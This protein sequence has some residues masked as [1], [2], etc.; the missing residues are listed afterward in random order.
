MEP[1]IR[2]KGF[3]SEWSKQKAQEIFKTY[4]DRNHPELPVLSA[5]QDIRGMAPRSTSGYDIFHD[6]ANEVTY[7]RVLPGQFVIHLRSFQGGFAHSAIEGICSPAYTVFEFKNKDEHD[8]Y[9]WKHVLRSM[10]F[11]ERLPLITYGIRD[12]RSISFKEFSDLAFNFPEKSEQSAIASFFKKMYNQIENTKKKITSFRQMR[13]ASLQAMFPQKGSTKPQIRFKGFNKDWEMNTLDSY[14]IPS[15]AKNTD[16]KYSKEDV[17]SVSGEYGIVNQIAFQG[18]SFAGLS[19]L[20]YGVVETKN[21]VYTKSPLKLNPYGIIK[22]N[23]GVTGIVSTLYAIYKCVESVNPTFVQYY[24]ELDS[25]LNDYLRPL[26]QKGAKNDMKISSEGALIGNVVFPSYDEQTQIADYFKTL[27]KKIQL[28]EQKLE[29]LKRIK[30]ACL[31]KMF[32]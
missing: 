22:A 26:V 32:V 24:F 9:Y 20:N 2:I 5:C 16:G 29:S 12:G 27:D 17:L 4:D 1:T 19:V 11:I 3:E 31:D 25:R 23:E 28:E 6:K 30:S 8:D 15:K 13:V 14:L 10:A 7:K 18:R 21:I